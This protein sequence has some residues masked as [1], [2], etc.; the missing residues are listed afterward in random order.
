MLV[1]RLSGDLTSA[2]RDLK[3]LA[4]RNIDAGAIWEGCFSTA[5]SYYVFVDQMMSDSLVAASRAQLYEDNFDLQLS[6]KRVEPNFK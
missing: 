5:Q 6:I 2:M 3:Q 1:Y 4:T